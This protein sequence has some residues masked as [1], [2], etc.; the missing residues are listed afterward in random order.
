MIR[1]MSADGP[2][3]ASHRL[4]MI[5][6]R[7]RGR[8]PIVVGREPNNYDRYSY[9]DILKPVFGG[10]T[11]LRNYQLFLGSAFMDHLG[12]CS[13]ET[14]KNLGEDLRVMSNTWSAYA[15]VR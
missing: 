13:I 15:A 11:K 10:E 12:P 6:D 4:L 3:V 5:R 8:H 7:C 2:I 14:F 9:N 1:E